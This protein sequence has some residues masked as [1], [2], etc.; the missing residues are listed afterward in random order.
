MRPDVVPAW[1]ELAEEAG[2]DLLTTVGRHAYPGLSDTVALA[3]AAAVTS[4]IELTQR[5]PAG[6]HLARARCW[7]RKWPGSTGC[8]AVG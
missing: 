5:R 6:H 7:P 4:R 1:A 8:P 2:F 3:A